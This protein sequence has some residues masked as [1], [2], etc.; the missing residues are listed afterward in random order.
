[1]HFYQLL[2]WGGRPEQLVISPCPRL[3]NLDIQDLPM[4]GQPVHQYFLFYP[5]HQAGHTE[6]CLY[7]KSKIMSIRSAYSKN[8]LFNFENKITAVL[9]SNQLVSTGLSGS[10][11]LVPGG[12]KSRLFSLNLLHFGCSR[13]S[14]CAWPKLPVSVV[15][16]NIVSAVMPLPYPGLLHSIGSLIINR[17]CVNAKI[18]AHLEFGKLLHK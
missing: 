11:P 8:I 17:D 12:L 3:K 15:L 10:N 18:S 7:L 14:S 1:M 4:T 16:L 2:S 13:W 9:S 5:K 6:N